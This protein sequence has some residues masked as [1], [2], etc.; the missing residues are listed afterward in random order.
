[1]VKNAQKKIEMMQAFMKDTQAG[2][3]LKDKDLTDVK[4]LISVKDCM[5]VVY[6]KND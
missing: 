2:A 5:E 4:T 3:T 1:M 6:N